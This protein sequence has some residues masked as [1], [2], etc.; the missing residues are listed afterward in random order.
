MSAQ[1][2]DLKA[3]GASVGFVQDRT[4]DSPTTLGNVW[5]IDKQMVATCAHLISPYRTHLP[6]LKVVFPHSRKEWAVESF[7]FHPKFD[8]KKAMRMTNVSL[9]ETV[10][11]LAVQM[12]NAVVL[13]LSENLP[14]VTEELV[15][16]VNRQL[17]LPAPPREHGLGGNLGEIDLYVVVQTITNARKEGIITIWVDRNFPTARLFC[18][19]GRVMY[20]TYQNLS[21]EMAVYQ[22]VN[23]NLRGN[24]HFW[25]AS[26]PNWQASRAISRPTDMVLIESH[27]RFDELKRLVP[28]IGDASTLILRNSS[29]PN[30]G[31]LPAEVKDYTK[32]L[33]P[34]LDGGIPVGQLWQLAGIDDFAVYSSLYNLLQTNQVQVRTP[35]PVTMTQGDGSSELAPL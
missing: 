12:H 32:M 2:S 23:K 20:A 9:T 34:L 6:A 27:R 7:M 19:N 1:S 28:M 24:F 30:Y 13:K 31:V 16:R 22:I 21:N 3:F 4:V 14:A 29:E 33:W 35:A 8:I 10:P 17:S 18:Q 11:S 26:K 15:I 5:V 25:S